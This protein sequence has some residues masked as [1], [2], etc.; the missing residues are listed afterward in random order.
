MIYLFFRADIWVSQ[1]LSLPSSNHEPRSES[2]NERELESEGE[3]PLFSERVL[4]ADEDE[5]TS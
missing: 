3:R 4:K 1:N 2:A 5:A